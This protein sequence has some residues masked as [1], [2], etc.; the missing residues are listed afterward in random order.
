MKKFLL[1]VLFGFLAIVAAQPGLPFAMA[2][3]L[4]KDLAYE[5]SSLRTKDHGL[6]TTLSYHVTKTMEGNPFLLP[7]SVVE[8][9][10]P[11]I[12]R[13]AED[14]TFGK[15]TN[16]EKSIAIYTWVTENLQYDV[17]TYF[18]AIAGRPF[19]FKSATEA[20]R[21]RKAMCMGFSHLTAALHRAA[22]IEAKVVYGADHAWNEIRIDGKWVPQ[23]TT[24]GAGYIDNRY[25]EFIHKP[26]LD[27]LFRTD[28][29]KE[30]EYLW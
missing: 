22:G 13:I 23:D 26:N 6:L 10:D 25:R 12:V 21:T 9:G 5:A 4:S 1:I 7:S 2:T 11:E 28:E 3:S 16:K 15:N 14:V 24:R 8:S 20:L 29:F 30:G 19:E 17:A 18:D 27:Y